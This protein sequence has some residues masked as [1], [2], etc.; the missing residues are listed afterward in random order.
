L[1]VRITPQAARN[2]AAVVRYVRERNPAASETVAAAIRRTISTIGQ[3]PSAGH[4][5]TAPR[6][7]KLAIPHY[8]YL[9]YFAV[10]QADQVVLILAVQHAARRR[11]HTDA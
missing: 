11:R 2:I 8:P 10:D 5:Q 3:F 9:I 1:R 7:R 4:A 6:V